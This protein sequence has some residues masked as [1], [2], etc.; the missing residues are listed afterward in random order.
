MIVAITAYDTAQTFQ[1]CY[2]AGITQ[3]LTKPVKADML[4]YVV[5]FHNKMEG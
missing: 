2:D 5:E 1:K 4:K 3:C